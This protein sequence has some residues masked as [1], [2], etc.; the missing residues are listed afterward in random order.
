M[1]VHPLPDYDGGSQATITKESGQ[2]GRDT[3]IPRLRDLGKGDVRYGEEAAALMVHERPFSAIRLPRC[4]STYLVRAEIG[5]VG[6]HV[7]QPEHSGSVRRSAPTIWSIASS[8]AF[9]THEKS[10]TQAVSAAS[11]RSGLS[12]TTHPPMNTSSRFANKRV[13]TTDRGPAQPAGSELHCKL[14][15]AEPRSAL[16]SAE[17]PDTG[18]GSGMDGLRHRHRRGAILDER[19]NRD[20][21]PSEVPHREHVL[22]RHTAF[23][24][25]ADAAFAN[26]KVPG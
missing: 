6:W 14:E 18:A 5:R 8:I 21:C 22:G 11:G 16:V 4:A 13:S 17:V 25:L 2:N 3:L 23:S 10:G 26:T 19:L 12:V 1:G 15:K 20:L 7:L 24:H 9:T